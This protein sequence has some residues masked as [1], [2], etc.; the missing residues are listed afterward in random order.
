MAKEPTGRML[1][2]SH[3]TKAVRTPEV[4]ELV[5]VRTRRW[6]VEDIKQAETTGQSPLVTLACADDDAQG[7][8]LTVYWDY[9]LDRRILE[10]E[11]W[12]DLAAKGF[13]EGR[14]VPHAVVTP[15]NRGPS[16]LPGDVDLRRLGEVSSEVHLSAGAPFRRPRR[17]YGH[18]IEAKAKQ[19]KE[20]RVV[21][22][23]LGH[24]R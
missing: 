10:D 23:D 20:W 12:K 2:P 5:L 24:V 8:M 7:Q 22:E 21:R 14:R 13:D 1:E 3:L 15:Y 18:K 11:G 9:E 19:L 17:V 6:L 16:P 4:G